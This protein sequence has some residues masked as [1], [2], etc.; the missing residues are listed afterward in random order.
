M[1]VWKQVLMN[2]AHDGGC[3]DIMNVDHAALAL[4]LEKCDALKGKSR[5]H[6]RIIADHDNRMIMTT[7]SRLATPPKMYVQNSSSQPISCL[8][9]NGERVLPLSGTYATPYS[10][11]VWNYRHHVT[12][13]TD[14]GS[15]EWNLCIS[16]S[17]SINH[18][19]Q[20]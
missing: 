6:L 4:H 14:C 12:T 11:L 19:N 10:S 13:R 5:P 2:M 9:R 20:T 17:F 15:L 3:V 8:Q 7:T 1:Q 16:L 18:L